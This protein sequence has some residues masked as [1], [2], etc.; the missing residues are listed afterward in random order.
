[1]CAALCTHRILDRG[2]SVACVRAR[3]L[4]TRI[5]S[6]YRLSVSPAQ[7]DVR[8][9]YG[10]YSGG[11]GGGGS[12]RARACLFASLVARHPPGVPTADDH[13]KH[14]DGDARLPRRQGPR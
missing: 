13:Q 2:Y 5:L 1:M 11:G 8:V 6:Y 14:V 10:D 9:T 12:A 3:N 7:S 4:T